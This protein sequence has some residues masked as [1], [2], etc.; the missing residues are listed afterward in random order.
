L[1]QV[2]AGYVIGFF[3][4]DR[5]Q[6]YTSE[7]F[8][9]HINNKPLSGFSLW[10]SVFDR[11]GIIN[12]KLSYNTGLKFGVV[13][14]FRTQ[15]PKNEIPDD[16]INQIYHSYFFYDPYT[17]TRLQL[18]IPLGIRY[19]FLSGKSISKV[20]FGTNFGTSLNI[21]T[22]RDEDKKLTN[23]TTMTPLILQPYFGFE[24]GKIGL[25][26]TLEFDLIK[27]DFYD[28]LTK[29]TLGL[30]LTYRFF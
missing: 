9:S 2:E 15:T 10:L 8:I 30:S 16:T 5:F 25:L 11:E 12:K 23:F 17:I 26:S 19:S 22:F 18:I 4:K 13:D 21:I 24:Y 29:Y 3:N 14:L 7:H 28:A 27:G 6:Y 1:S 20:S